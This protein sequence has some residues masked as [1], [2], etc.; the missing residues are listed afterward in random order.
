M[1]G[2][3]FFFLAGLLVVPL[4]LAICRGFGIYTIV[5][6]CETQVFTLFGKVIGTMDQPGLRLPIVDYGPRALLIPFFGKKKVLFQ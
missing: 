3:I 2:N 5:G 4:A 6:E 1:Y